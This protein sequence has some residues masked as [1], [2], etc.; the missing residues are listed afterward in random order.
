VTKASEQG[1]DARGS[2]AF[3]F[4][5]ELGVCELCGRSVGERHLRFVVL[6]RKT[7]KRLA[8]GVFACDRHELGPQGPAE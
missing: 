4:K 1:T 2:A 6:K 3:P 7:K 5:R 8:H